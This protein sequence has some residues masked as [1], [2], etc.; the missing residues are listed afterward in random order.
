MGEWNTWS[1][2]EWN[3]RLL[4]HFFRKK[5]DR[6]GAVSVLL[7]T[8]DE[9]ARVAGNFSA[10][11]DAVRDAF[12]DAVRDGIRRVK[13]LLEH[14]SDYQGWPRLA[15][16]SDANPR[17]VAHLLFTC[18]AASESS[19]DL[20]DERS[21]VARLRE[22]TQD[23][24]PDHSLPSLPKL[25]NHF[26][27]WLS[28][29]AG[30]YRALHLPEP[31]G[32]TRIG[33]TTKLAFPDRR[34]LRQLSDLLDRAGL[35]GAEPPV[36]RVLTLVAAER[37][38]FK[39]TF[40]RALDEFRRLYETGERAKQASLAEHRL[41]AA[42]REA[43][44]RGRGRAD[45]EEV[46]AR[47]TLLCE[48]R[49][50]ILCPFA[51]SAEDP[52]SERCRFEEFP[53][54]G[55]GEWRF[56]VL[57]PSASLTDDCM[58]DAVSAIF[59]G[60]LRLP[61]VSA[62]VDQG[63]LPFVPSRHGPLEL[64]RQDQLSEASVAL[65]REE[66]QEDFL[67]FFGEGTTVRRSGF[68]GWVQVH[69]PRLRVLSPELVDQSTLSRTWIVHESLFPTTIR[70]VGG[71]RADD[72][73]LGAAEVLPSIVMPDA[74]SVRVLD[75]STEDELTRAVDGKWSFSGRDYLGT[76]TIVGTTSEGAIER[77]S[78]TFYSAPASETFRKPGEPESWIVEVVEGTGTM[79]DAV[80]LGVSAEARDCGSLS[81][82]TAF[83]GR[84]VGQFVATAAEAVWEVTHFGSRFVGR[85]GA[86]HG[87]DAVPSQRAD[88]A[89]A[90]QRWR[91]MLLKS[92]AHPSDPEFDSA[93]RPVR[94]ASTSRALPTF[95]TSSPVP[96]LSQISL[97][98][99]SIK[100]TRLAAIVAGRA[101][102]RSGISWREWRD[103]STRVLGV[104]D[105]H[106]RLV[107][108]SWMEAGLVDVGT[109]ARWRHVAVFAREPRLVCFT[110]STGIGGTVSGLALPATLDQL[111]TVASRLGIAA[112]ERRS[113]S[114]WTPESVTFRASSVSLLEELG[115]RCGIGVAWL[116]LEA[117]E[118]PRAARH[119]GRTQQP[120]H[121]E[122]SAQWARWSLCG[123]EV[124]GVTF[125]HWVRNDRPSHWSLVVGAYRTWS[126]DLNQARLWAAALLGE[127]ALEVGDRCITAK[128]AFLPL[129]LARSVA[130]LGSG[131]AGAN[132]GG[133]YR[134]P[135]QCEALRTL[136][137]SVVARTFDPSRL[138]GAAEQA[139]G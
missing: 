3:D 44:L 104:D 132:E 27:T 78:L 119:D 63:V 102:S 118:H 45:I 67:R 85:R 58:Q 62:Q 73:F 113:V 19:D 51:A 13:S 91:T 100:A 2:Q 7:V 136:V 22:L 72:G 49:E 54:G 37:G 65:V 66:L 106:A 133:A 70:V 117:V 12:V 114:Q 75:G 130:V 76:V 16:P 17:F 109:S 21:F 111:R 24:L 30:R 87:G 127:G 50:D 43:S 47:I 124:P 64:A 108:R 137:L 122:R 28:E 79:A 32:L 99:P 36:G 116:D 40:L 94:G 123:H 41:W 103:L 53:Y 14:A 56:A 83:L 98:K 31:G 69:E 90:R 93:R 23:Q 105:R 29:N 35:S 60:S 101:S 139:T 110:S 97:S 15:P 84:D 80:G 120:Q 57:K 8:A 74:A 10:D 55:Y 6:A 96:D 61:Y 52:A 46:P 26:A 77:A 81:E 134:Y 126:Y 82:R 125:T 39:P 129:P 1:L 42:V 59:S 95:E 9:L 48:D 121:Y 38:K 68:P 86:F 131:L 112:E 135:V 92:T 11:P 25:W 107:T 5:D 18:V 89:H 71:V 33:Y 4:E 88:D 128:H 115:R 34:D 138:A 20:G